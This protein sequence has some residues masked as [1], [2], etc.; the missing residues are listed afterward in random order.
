MRHFL[1]L[2]YH[3]AGG[4]LIWQQWKSHLHTGNLSYL[5]LAPK[6]SLVRCLYHP[7]ASCSACSRK[8]IRTR[9]RK[10]VIVLSRSRNV[11]NYLLVLLSHFTESYFG[12]TQFTASNKITIH[13]KKIKPFTFYENNLRSLANHENTLNHP[14]FTSKFF[15]GG[16]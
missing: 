13:E 1:D 7:S 8:E 14:L 2:N 15:V 4:A 10:G 9:K 16:V 12:K 5:K 11:V 3:F 6:H